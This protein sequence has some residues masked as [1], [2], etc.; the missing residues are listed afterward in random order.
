MDESSVVKTSASPLN[1]CSRPCVG[2][3]NDGAVNVEIVLGGTVSIQIIQVIAVI[4]GFCSDTSTIG[5]IVLCTRGQ[6][7]EV[8]L[9]V[10]DVG[11]SERLITTIAGVHVVAHEIDINII[12]RLITSDVGHGTRNIQHKHDVRRNGS[13]DKGGVTRCEGFQLDPVG[14]VR[15]R[16]GDVLAVSEAGAVVDM[17]AVVLGP[18]EN[19]SILEIFDLSVDGVFPVG[20]ISVL[21]AGHRRNGEQRRGGEND[22]I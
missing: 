15:L 19:R 11:I 4:I 5:R 18:V 8:V 7:I 13:L 17:D 2:L 10:V 21:G 12:V 3:F 14:T 1:S 16:R 9:V 6:V 22:A 20:G